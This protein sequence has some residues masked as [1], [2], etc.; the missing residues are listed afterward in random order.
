MHYH[1]VPFIHF[2]FP[3]YSLLFSRDSSLHK[4]TGSGS[5]TRSR[6]SQGRKILR[7][8]RPDSITRD[9][10][11]NN[12]IETRLS[13]K[14]VRTTRK[15]ARFPITKFDWH[16]LFYELRV[17]PCIFVQVDN[18]FCIVWQFYLAVIKFKFEEKRIITGKKFG[19]WKFET[20]DLKVRSLVLEN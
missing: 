14:G 4:G 11:C 9:R 17:R 16:L 20:I 2:S 1:T 6:I 10:T 13:I 8:L 5:F 3:L 12:P 15:I 18:T 7:P 19:I